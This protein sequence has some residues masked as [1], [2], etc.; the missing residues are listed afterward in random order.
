MLE[1]N[2]KKFI[3]F[4]LSYRRKKFEK[5]LLG[6]GFIVNYDEIL[7]H[8]TYGGSGHTQQNGKVI[9]GGSITSKMANITGLLIVSI[10]RS[11][12]FMVSNMSIHC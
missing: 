6:K 1:Y 2:K 9:G 10:L 11:W 3:T 8:G 12:F 5:D 7:N 4:H